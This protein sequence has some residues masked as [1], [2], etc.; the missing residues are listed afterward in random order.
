MSDPI[1]FGANNR[2]G[3]EYISIPASW[4]AGRAKCDLDHTVRI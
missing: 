1:S 3:A 2:P 4:N